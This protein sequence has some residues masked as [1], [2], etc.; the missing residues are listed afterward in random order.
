MNQ[1]LRPTEERELQAIVAEHA[2]V[3]RGL[4]VQGGGTKQRI[5]RQVE[6]GTL[7]STRNLRGITLFEPSELVISARA[8]TTLAAVEAELGKANLRCAFEPLDLAPMLGETALQSTIGGVVAT[9]LSGARR[10]AVGGT[11]HREGA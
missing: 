1:I 7:L 6:P 11:G 2:R 3:N 9:N 8:G 10:I 4:D 5:G